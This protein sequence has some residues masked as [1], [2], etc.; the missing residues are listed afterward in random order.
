MTDWREIESQVFMTTGRRL[1]VVLVRGEGTRVWDEDGKS[2]L[3]FFGGP[4]VTSLGHCHPV[5][6]EALTDQARK[7]I[8]VSNLVYSVPQLQLA[9]LLVQHSGLDRVYF[10]NSGA[11]ANEAAIKLARKWGHEH[12]DG[13]YEIIATLDAFHGRTL[14]TVTAGGSDRYKQPFAPLPPGFVHVPY[15]DIEAIKKATSERTCAVLLEPVQGE[16]GVIVPD[17]GYLPAVR[18]WCD[19]QNILLMLDEVQT[20]IG[21]C[22]ALFA[23]QLAG[24]EPDVL[25]LAKGIASG[26]PLAAVLAKEHC[27]VFTPGDH[28]STYGGNPL[29]TRA[30]YEVVRYVIDNELPAKAAEDGHYLEQRLRGLE[31]RLDVVTDVRGKGLFWAV[32]LAREAAQEVVLSCLERGLIV[33]NVRPDAVRLAPPLTV[34]R[35]ELDEALA[36]LE[37]VLVELGGGPAK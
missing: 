1:P 27:A 29:A 32:G 25:T 2:Y 37:G 12:R 20:G 34:S 11:E 33:N 31:D 21:R 8:H 16:G 3:D 4:S 36:T 24:I 7:L 5:L 10:A 6:V 18:R 22:G 13:A 30:G 26:V 28:G 23:Y 14:A 35:E 17:D 19:E 15:N 9:Q